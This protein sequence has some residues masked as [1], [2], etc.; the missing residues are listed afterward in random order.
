MTLGFPT[1]LI[2]VVACVPRDRYKEIGIICAK[3]TGHRIPL[4]AAQGPR[5]RCLG[6]SLAARSLCDNR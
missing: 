5:S 6:N 4:A 1:L 3:D 2:K